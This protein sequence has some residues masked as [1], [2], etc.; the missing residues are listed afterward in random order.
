VPAAQ[1]INAKPRAE[2]RGNVKT[3]VER[4]MYT[5]SLQMRLDSI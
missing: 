3:P 4:Y 2:R 5:A 1:P